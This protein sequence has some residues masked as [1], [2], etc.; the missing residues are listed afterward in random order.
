MQQFCTYEK[1]TGA[2][3]PAVKLNVGCTFGLNAGGAAEKLNP[4]LALPEAAG[5]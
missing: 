5:C 1:E 3:V 4:P 2:P